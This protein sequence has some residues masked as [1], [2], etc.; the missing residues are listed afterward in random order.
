MADAPTRAQRAAA[1][2]EKRRRLDDLKKRRNQRDE[3]TSKLKPGANLDEYIDG[4]LSAP[5]AGTPSASGEETSQGRPAP[6]Q[7]TNTENASHTNAENASGSGSVASPQSFTAAVTE[8]VIPLKQVE[9][10]TIS[11]Q[12]EP[13]EFLEVP[14]EDVV[15]EDTT[16]LSE[17]QPADYPDASETAEHGDDDQQP[18]ILPIDQVKKDVASE[19]FV[20]FINTASKKVERMLGAPLLDD[21]LV[22]YVGA[23]DRSREEKVSDESRFV[24]SRQIFECTS[25]TSGR[26]VTDIDWSLLHRELFLATYHMPSSVGSTM[27]PKGSSAVSTVTQK[28]TLS[29][30]MTPRSG[31]LVSDGLAMVWSLTMPTRPEHIFTCGSPVTC[32]KFHP[33][34]PT[35]ILGGCESGQLVIWDTRSGRLPVQKSALISV[36]GAS[37]KGHAYPIGCMEVIEGGVSTN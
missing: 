18:A 6:S 12:T 27:V 16:E 30:S 23:S 10:F 32:G 15:E 9:T 5:A 11:T 31:D 14:D 17:A 8:P 1:L 2:E 35:L 28:E 20:S 36:T 13:G 37:S 22:D 34:E 7:T 24:S 4:L 25:W 29:A 26:D 19:A 33:T 21:L 3:D